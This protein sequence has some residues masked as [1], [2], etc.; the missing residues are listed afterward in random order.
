[1]S[2]RN[3][4]SMSWHD[5]QQYMNSKYWYKYLKWMKEL[6]I[7]F[8]IYSNVW[9]KMNVSVWY[10]KWVRA[11]R[12]FYSLHSSNNNLTKKCWY[13][14]VKHVWSSISVNVNVEF[15]FFFVLNFIFL[16]LP[17]H[18]ICYVLFQLRCCSYKSHILMSTTIHS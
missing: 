6:C 15:S 14:K 5:E 16:H 18:R 4:I 7:L 9:A 3:Q 13:V 8:A 1:M 2:K 17:L 11:Y 12:K 10:W